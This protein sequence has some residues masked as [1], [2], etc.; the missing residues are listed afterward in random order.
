LATTDQSAV[1]AALLA[2]CGIQGHD[3]VEM[4]QRW[5]RYGTPAAPNPSRHMVYDE[6]YGLFREA[7]APVVEV[8]HRLGDWYAASTGP[9]V[10]PRPIRK[11][12]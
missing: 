1:G 2:L 5:A 8:S 12:E 9:R 7:Y 10:V 4:A 3:P 11:R 6:V